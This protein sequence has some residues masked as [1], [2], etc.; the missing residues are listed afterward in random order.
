MTNEAFRSS[1]FKIQKRPGIS[2]SFF[3]GDLRLCGM[4]MT[5]NRMQ[6]EMGIFSPKTVSSL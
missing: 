2:R 4:V 5:S 1:R 6:I 3:A